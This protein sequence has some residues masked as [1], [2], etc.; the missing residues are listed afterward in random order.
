MPDI[1]PTRQSRLRAAWPCIRSSR[2]YWHSALVTKLS[3][4]QSSGLRARP[5]ISTF[6]EQ[7][8][9][10]SVLRLLPSLKPLAWQSLSAPSLQSGAPLADVGHIARPATIE[11][12]LARRDRPSPA[13]LARALKSSALSPRLFRVGNIVSD[14]SNSF[15]IPSSSPGLSSAGCGEGD[16]V[17]CAAGSRVPRGGGGGGRRGPPPPPL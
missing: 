16:G 15:P 4:R 7:V 6:G 12:G 11:D 3:V 14:F 5:G 13:S 9:A 17:G 10:E 8:S 2:H 1:I